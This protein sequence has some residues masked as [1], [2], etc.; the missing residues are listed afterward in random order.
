M[1]FLIKHLLFILEFILIVPVVI[2]IYKIVRFS[3]ASLKNLFLF[4]YAYLIQKIAFIIGEW[5]GLVKLK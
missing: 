2:K 5:Q 4:F 1:K 3:K